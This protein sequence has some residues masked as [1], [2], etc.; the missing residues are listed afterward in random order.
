MVPGQNTEEKHAEN[1]AEYK[2][3]ENRCPSIA[4]H[5]LTH[6]SRKNVERVH[7]PKKHWFHN[8]KLQL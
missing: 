7:R 5:S 1:N 2:N 3:A 8:M 6:A 4:N